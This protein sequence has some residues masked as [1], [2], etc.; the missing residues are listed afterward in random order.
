MNAIS[1]IANLAMKI[2]FA[3]NA[4]TLSLLVKMRRI[5]N[6]LKGLLNKMETNAFVQL[7]NSTIPKLIILVPY[8]QT[9]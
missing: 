5:V 9:Q 4:R 6:A 8:A 3:F 7:V 1:I 2:M